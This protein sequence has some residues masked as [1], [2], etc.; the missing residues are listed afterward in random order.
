MRLHKRQEEA[1]SPL[2]FSVSG[3]LHSASRVFIFWR[4]RTQC[5]KS[6]LL[7]A[8]AFFSSSEPKFF[9]LDVINSKKQLP[10]N[11]EHQLVHPTKA[12]G[13]EIFEAYLKTIAYLNQDGP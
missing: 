13:N 6:S 2:E 11:A 8:Q 3:N 12:R 9:E 5:L 10:I 1:G 7:L 4:I